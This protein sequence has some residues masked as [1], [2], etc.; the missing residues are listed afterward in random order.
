[1]VGHFLL[2]QR[3]C[4]LAVGLLFMLLT[5]NPAVGQEGGVPSAL[6]SAL[7]QREQSCIR[8]ETE[9]DWTRDVPGDPAAVRRLEQDIQRALQSHPPAERA[10]VEPDIRRMYSALAYGYR[11]QTRWVLRGLGDK[12]AFWGDLPLLGKPEVRT[13]YRAIIYPN[14]VLVDGRIVQPFAQWVLHE[15]VLLIMMTGMSPLELLQDVQVSPAEG[16]QRLVILQG[17]MK[18]VDAPYSNYASDKPLWITIDLDKGG[19]VA[20]VQFARPE[21]REGEVVVREW[22]RFRELWL[23]SRIVLKGGAGGSSQELSLISVRDSSLKPPEW[24]RGG[25]PVTDTRLVQPGEEGVMYRLS[26]RLPSLQ[27]LEAMRA[28]ATPRRGS[29]WSPWWRIIPP[30]L[31]ITIGVLWYWRLRRAEGKE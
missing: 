15:P 7:R 28:K 8:L 4:F 22:K 30:V 27:E 9:W 6:V 26:D 25:G 21:G 23:P 10:K 31:L 1:M 13:P 12:Y 14:G 19:A 17:R 11:E 18:K 24:F 16:N 5:L 3:V 29:V 20:G 2:K